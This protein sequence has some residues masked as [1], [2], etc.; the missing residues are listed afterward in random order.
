M[1]Q[2][3]TPP[4]GSE[5][6]KQLSFRPPD[7]AWAPSEALAEARAALKRYDPFLDLW[8]SPVIR[9]GDP[10]GNT[11]RWTIKCW[12]Q[13]TGGWDTVHIWEGPNREFRNEFPVDALIE[14]VAYK[15]R[16]RKI[17]T[18]GETWA[19]RIERMHKENDALD[20]K[21][22]M[23]HRAETFREAADKAWYD[24]GLRFNVP[25]TSEQSRFE[26]RQARLRAKHRRK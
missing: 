10:T 16:W 21:R 20:Q 5:Q 6:E 22:E 23:T 11:G 1:R 26:K 24:G 15:D 4:P 8:W 13:K 17:E 7:P 12:E 19:Q 14:V 2:R 18:A 25:V 9:M 3:C